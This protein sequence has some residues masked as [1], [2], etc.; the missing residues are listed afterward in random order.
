M[1]CG[2][3][4]VLSAWPFTHTGRILKEDFPAAHE[5]VLDFKCV[6][7]VSKHPPSPITS[8]KSVVTYTQTSRT[9]NGNRAVVSY[10]YGSRNNGYS[11]SSEYS[12][13]SALRHV[14]TRGL[15]AMC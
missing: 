15:A 3:T 6:V 8:F 9:T 5:S 4:A 1:M 10:A 14:F 7:L 13:C 11:E 12:E 2:R